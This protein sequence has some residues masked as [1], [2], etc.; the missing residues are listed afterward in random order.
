MLE[1]HRTFRE[2]LHAAAVNVSSKLNLCFTRSGNHRMRRHRR[3]VERSTLTIVGRAGR[4][5]A[6]A[7]RARLNIAIVGCAS[8]NIRTAGQPGSS[9]ATICGS[10]ERGHIV[11]C[12]RR[13]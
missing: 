11:I 1:T 6:T 10:A 12:V 8:R 5:I 7:G 2:A 3:D 13:Q 4:N 9:P